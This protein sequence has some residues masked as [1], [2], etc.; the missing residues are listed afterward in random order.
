[1][2][3]MGAGMFMGDVPPALSDGR[4]RRKAISRETILA[5]C[6]RLMADGHFRPSMDFC[7]STADRSIRTG[8]GLFGTVEALHF[9]ALQD[10][11]TR[12]AIFERILGDTFC[13]VTDGVEGEERIL[14]AIVTGKG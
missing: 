1:M 14:R 10:V 11:P 13:V 3:V 6:R 4:N 8:F 7:C 9:E 2:S 12:N 5:A